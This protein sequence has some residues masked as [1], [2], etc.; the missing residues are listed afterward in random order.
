LP[1]R[2]G[3]WTFL[4][5]RGWVWVPGRVATTTWVPF[6]VVHNAPPAYRPPVPPQRLG[7]IG[8]T[9]SAF[10]A[11]A[12]GPRIIPIGN[13]GSGPVLPGRGPIRSTD[14]DALQTWHTRHGFDQAV[15][16]S[17]MAS[18]ATPH[19][20]VAVA[21]RSGVTNETTA[22]VVVR[23]APGTHAGMPGEPIVRPAPQTGRSTEAVRPM[24][25]VQPPAE[26]SRPMPQPRSAEAPRPVQHVS[27]PP[28][29]PHMSAPSMSTGG[30]HVSHTPHR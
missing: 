6:P 10:G 1:Y 25:R 14:L 28:P 3:S 21:G 19:G 9:P 20:G 22:P 29:A 7:V 12:P 4:R 8:G 13:G 2:Y 24:P 17:G 15:V 11:T 23:S 16:A 5:G 27:A 30:G 26:S 18:T